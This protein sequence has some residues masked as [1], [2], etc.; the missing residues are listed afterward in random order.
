MQLRVGMVV[1][2]AAI[3]RDACLIPLFFQVKVQTEVVISV[4]YSCQWDMSRVAIVREKYL[5]NEFFSMSG[6]FVDGQGNLERT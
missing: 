3:L 2:L 1:S 6:N 5:E 4:S